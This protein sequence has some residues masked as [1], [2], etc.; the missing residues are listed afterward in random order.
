MQIKRIYWRNWLVESSSIR[1]RLLFDLELCEK[2][3]VDKAS[4]F[5]NLMVLDICLQVGEL[6][7]QVKATF[8]VDFT[9]K[10]QEIWVIGCRF[11]N[12]KFMFQNLD[13][14][15]EHKSMFVEP[16]SVKLGWWLRFWN[17][18]PSSKTWHFEK[19]LV[20]ERPIYVL[21]PKV[22]MNKLI[23][24]QIQIRLILFFKIWDGPGS[25]CEKF[26]TRDQ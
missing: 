21:K 10:R 5:G 2:W 9:I 14:I 13:Y 23:S 7:D 26:L 18:E 25:S 16:K 19:C 11:R 17:I 12:S 24:V 22:V 4:G 20:P 3:K 6:L 8:W 15:W 1:A